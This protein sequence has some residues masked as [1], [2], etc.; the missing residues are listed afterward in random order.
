M[1]EKQYRRQWLRW[2]SQYEKLAYKSLIKG[3][4]EVGNAIP[5]DF[6]TVDN[7]DMVL[8][9]S[10]KSELFYNIY[11]ELY[12][13]VGIIHGERVGKTINKEI[14]NFTLETFLS[15]FEQDLLGWLFNN[16]SSRIVTV[17]NTYIKAIKE[18][19]SFGIAE[20][21]SMSQIAT[22]LKA[23]INQRGFYR[24]QALRIART[25]TTSAANYASMQAGSVTGILLEKIWISAADSR[26]RRPP[27]SEYNHMKMNGVKVA[28]D[29]FFQVP[30][31]GGFEKMLYPS[32]PKNGSAGNVINCRCNAA[33]IPV[34]DKDGRIVR[35]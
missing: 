23:K 22:E 31:R 21:K 7:Y 5:F 12:K 13:E 19:I 9:G 34:R 30:F 27:K 4:K 2:H 20:G 11:Y 35:V 17:R 25:E 29:E 10:F 26:T 32:D 8:D 18:L 16:S 28:K 33:L 6:L 3:F 15:R 1:T 24:W 14:K